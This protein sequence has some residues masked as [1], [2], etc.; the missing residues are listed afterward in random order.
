MSKKGKRAVT[1]YVPPT[2]TFSPHAFCKSRSTGLASGPQTNLLS[3]LRQSL[4]TVPV[5]FERTCSVLL[6]LSGIVATTQQAYQPSTVLLS[7]VSLGLR[8]MAFSVE[9]SLS[10]S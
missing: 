1:M 8:Y 6:R 10:F 4:L 5:Q 3:L 9:F 2:T 7:S